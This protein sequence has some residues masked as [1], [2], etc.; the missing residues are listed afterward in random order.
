MPPDVVW[1]P[2]AESFRILVARWR[3]RRVAAEFAEHIVPS[4]NVSLEFSELG[5]VS[6]LQATRS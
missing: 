2:F 4:E 5:S 3:E 1:N 6:S